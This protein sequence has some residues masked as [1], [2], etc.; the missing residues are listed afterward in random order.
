M[1]KTSPT[2]NKAKSLLGKL[3]EQIKLEKDNS[4]FL[5]TQ[6]EELKKL[7]IKLE[8]NP[9]EKAVVQ[10]LLQGEESKI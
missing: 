5:H 10:N 7:I 2:K 1:R 3:I 4:H 6:N 9:L 8:V